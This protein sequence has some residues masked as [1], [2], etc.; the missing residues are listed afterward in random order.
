[1]YLG[2]IVEVGPGDRVY[3][4]P[5]HPYTRAL[6]SAVPEPDPSRRLDRVLLTGEVP[7]PIDVPAGC[8]F[9]PR[10]WMAEEVCRTVD[11][12]LYTFSAAQ[13][14]ACHVTAAQENLTSAKEGIREATSSG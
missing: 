10:C 3:T 12:P 2:R 8:R 14:A 13:R 7:S 5:K 4:Q 9:H 1:M 6:L 11:P